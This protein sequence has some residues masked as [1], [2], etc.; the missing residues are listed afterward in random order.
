MRKSNFLSACLFALL[1]A[2][3][4]W[5]ALAEPNPAK[6]N[7]YADFGQWLDQKLF[8]NRELDERRLALNRFMEAAEE[9]EGALVTG[10]LSLED[11]VQRILGAAREHY[12]QHL[13]QIAMVE[14]G[15]SHEE[16][17]ARNIAHHIE[18]SAVLSQDQKLRARLQAEL[19][20][21]LRKRQKPMPQMVGALAA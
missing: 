1:A 20:E 5:Q 9:V 4:L 21:L 12:P 3:L 14:E 17:I 8:G 7:L 15:D 11:A 6:D 2:I 18:E 10:R 19:A 13:E 16:R